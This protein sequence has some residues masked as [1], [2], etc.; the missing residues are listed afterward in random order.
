MSNPFQVIGQTIGYIRVSSAD[1]KTERQL[2]GIACDKIFTE[3]VSAKDA[4]RPQLQACIEYC[5][6][7]DILVV[8]SLDRFA[9]NL[10][11][12]RQLV[13]QL[14][15][16]GV[17]VRFV[18][19][20]LTFGKDKTNTI[21]D[22]LLLN[23]LGAFAEFERNLIRE[24]QREGIAIAKAK[25]KYKGRER[26]LSGE[27]VAELKQKAALGVPKTVIAK[28]MGLSRVSVYR[29]LQAA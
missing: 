27:Q 7:G 16:K 17:T 23:L 5:R 21:F 18:K 19:E 22:Q 2:E 1:Q 13:E 11:D 3:K 24:R 14:V 28:E 26:V 20:N 8:H 12:L 6:E 4:N 9:R 25:G 10:V 29:Y 15:A